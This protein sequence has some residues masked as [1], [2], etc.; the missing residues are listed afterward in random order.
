MTRGGAEL[1]GR[2]A[3]HLRRWVAGHGRRSKEPGQG[4][5]WVVKRKVAP[6]YLSGYLPPAVVP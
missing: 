1:E 2:R 6:V 4:S 5:F 3:G